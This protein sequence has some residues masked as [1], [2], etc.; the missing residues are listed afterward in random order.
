VT[1]IPFR[2]TIAL[3][4]LAGALAPA[5]AQQWRMQY[6]YDKGK[7]SLAIADLAFASRERGV[8]AGV[9]EEGRRHKPVA[10][11]TSD[12]GAHWQTVELKDRPLSLFFL[13]ENEGWMVGAKDLWHTSEAGK[14]WRKIDGLPPG[15]LRVYFSDAQT[16]FAVG[17]KK[18]AYE[19]HDAGRHWKAIEAAAAPP[20]ADKSSAYTW[21]AFA[22]PKLGII[23]GWNIPPE[24]FPQR[25]PDWMDPEGALSRRETP[26]LS[27]QLTT[28]DGGNTWK[29]NSASL[30]GDI[31]RVRF[32]AGARGLGL[33]EYSNSFR[34][35]SEVYTLDWETGKNQTLYRD[36]KF[37]IT[38]VWLTPDGSVWLAGT[39]VPGQV[40]NLVPGKV[41]VLRSRG[42]ERSVWVVQ[43][44]DYRAVANRVVLAGSGQDLWMATDNGMILKFEQDAPSR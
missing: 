5:Y 44:V 15:I 42:S 24:R 18:K 28:R 16:G 12:G 27:Y 32:G 7:S 30:F 22:T 6:I 37:D 4:A 3:L 41:Q 38:D 8:A 29:S 25:F 31:T 19:T 40:R 34:Y 39:V 23:T 26:H 9:I 21:I 14:S 1:S 20:G 33:V 36:R 13:N 35:P 17:I 43:D 10:I 11:V 2:P